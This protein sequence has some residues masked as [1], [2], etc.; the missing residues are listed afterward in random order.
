MADVGIKTVLIAIVCG[1][2]PALIWLWFWLKEDKER[3][4]PKGLLLITFVLGMA[5]VIIVLPIEKFF[6]RFLISQTS[7]VIAWAVVEET[8]KYGAAAIVALRSKYA[9]EAIDFPIYLMTTALGF[10]ALENGLFLL[11][12]AVVGNATVSLLTGN[13]RFLGATLL[14]AT[15]SAIVGISLG[16][17]YYKGRRIQQLYLMWGLLGAIFLH[18]VFNFF[19]MKGTENFFQVFAFLWV[20]T[21]IVLLLFEKLRRIDY[22]LLG[23]QRA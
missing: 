7:I 14:H 13:L 9:D 6:D 16:L 17:A 4:E 15:A 11:N 1:L 21:I 22:E 19:I 8:F 12:P 2:V 23:K 10:A 18:S 20:V 3:P 5:T